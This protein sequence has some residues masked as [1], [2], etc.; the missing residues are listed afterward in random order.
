M[1]QCVLKTKKGIARTI[2]GLWY[3]EK[4]CWMNLFIQKWED[5]YKE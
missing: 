3:T 2:K 5:D 1:T 4:K